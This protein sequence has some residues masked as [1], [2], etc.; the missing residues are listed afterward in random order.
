MMFS[1][2]KLQTEWHNLANLFRFATHFSGSIHFYR[3]TKSF[4]CRYYI[5]RHTI[6]DFIS[7]FVWKY[8]VICWLN[9]QIRAVGHLDLIFCVL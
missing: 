1:V 6:P 4:N 9:K 8:F 7:T 5:V 3:P 2:R